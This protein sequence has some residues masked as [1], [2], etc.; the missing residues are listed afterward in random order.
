MDCIP[1]PK[2][3]LQRPGLPPKAVSNTSGRPCSFWRWSLGGSLWLGPHSQN[4]VPAQLRGLRIVPLSQGGICRGPL[5]GSPALPGSLPGPSSATET[6]ATGEEGISEGRES[7]LP[8]SSISPLLP[9]VKELSGPII[10]PKDGH[11]LTLNRAHG[12]TPNPA[13]CRTPTLPTD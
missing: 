3:H 11:A 9:R 10:L 13:L 12:L 1:E 7:L 5:R 2:S 4:Q 8:L 6:A